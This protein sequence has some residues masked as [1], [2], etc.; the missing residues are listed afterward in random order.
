MNFILGGGVAGLVSAYY[1]PDYQLVTDNIGGWQNRNTFQLGPRLLEVTPETTVFMKSLNLPISEKKVYIGYKAGNF[2]GSSNKTPDFTRK[3]ALKT[4]EHENVDAVM[5][6]N[7]DTL[8]VFDIDYDLILNTVQ[9]KAKVQNRMS[10]AKVT[11]IDLKDQTFHANYP[12]GIP[13]WNY[14]HPELWDHLINTLPI[15]LFCKLA[16]QDL[17]RDFTAFHTT[18]LKVKPTKYTQFFY[19]IY[20]YIYSLDTFWHRMSI[21]R[22]YAILEVKGTVDTKLD[23]LHDGSEIFEII[24][25]V[26]IPYAQIKYS[27]K[28]LEQIFPTV[29]NVG[30]YA[31][32]DHSIKME[33]IIEKFE[34]VHLQ[35]NKQAE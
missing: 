16:N 20:D 8:T 13:S 32:W 24:D 28:D 14:N 12:N 1:L 4:R 5:S 18:F 21:F 6:G 23:Y 9:E 22:D 10:L 33:Q 19:K 11:K 26:T 3:Y 7:R 29:T 15:N 30:R 25:K 35:N 34:H 27:Y 17:Q 31:C 2:T